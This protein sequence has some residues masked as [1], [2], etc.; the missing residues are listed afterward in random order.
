MQSAGVLCRNAILNLYLVRYVLR[1]I[2][3][4]FFSAL[5]KLGTKTA[6][7]I[8]FQGFQFSVPQLPGLS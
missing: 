2:K 6:Q 8:V 5:S 3:V 4:I 1:G 7:D